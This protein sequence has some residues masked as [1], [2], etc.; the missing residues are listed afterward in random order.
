[1]K[2]QIVILYIIM[3]L[4]L[5]LVA[6]LFVRV[7]QYKRQMRLFAKRIRQ[8]KE[9][10]MNQSVTVE[11]F[12]KDVVDLAI[13][14]QEYTDMVKSKTKLIE[15]E[16]RQLK[17]V[18]AG[19]S[20]DFRTPLTSAKGYMQLI[21]KSGKLDGKNLEYIDIALA[22]TDYLKTLSDA[23]FEVS[24]MEAKDEENEVSKVNITKLL[25][26]ICIG[27]YEWI[28]QTDLVTEFNI[29]EQDIYVISNEEML[30]RIFENFF[31]NASKYSKTYLK[32]DCITEENKVTLSFEN[33]IEKDT[34]IDIN[35]VF[36]AFYRDDSR[37]CE[38]AGL[39]LYVVKCLAEKL[40][41]KVEAEVG[42][43]VF[44]VRIILGV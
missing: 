35:H 41:H 4:L 42:S 26:E 21:K 15:A 2:N 3:E 1:M 12:D 36:D 9:E 40:K 17:N 31:S 5:V 23:F 18:I 38:G 19:I 37:H 11:Y 20:H 16:R 39:G 24:S 29:P 7:F 22:K 27:Q 8:R 32:L 14:L 34:N 33:D 10:D 44:K 43:D 6:I 30:K 25:S 28:S 13:A